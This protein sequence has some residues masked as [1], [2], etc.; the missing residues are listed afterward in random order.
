MCKFPLSG[1]ERSFMA[2]LRGCVYVL[3]KAHICVCVCVNILLMCLAVC[4]KGTMLTT[5]SVDNLE[6]L[7]HGLWKE[8]L[9]SVLN[10][11]FLAL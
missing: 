10:V 4:F 3:G 9:M 8:P 5:T 6:E 2:G 1:T 7:G 11:F